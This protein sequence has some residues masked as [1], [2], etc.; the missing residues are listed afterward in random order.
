MLQRLLLNLFA[1]WFRLSRWFPLATMQRLRDAIAEGERGHAGELCLAIEARYS[2]GAVLRGL[3]PRERA[4]QVFSLLRVWDTQDNSG[5]LLYLQL[6]ERRVELLAD[7]GIAARVHDDQWRAICDQFA[8]DMH[9]GPADVAALRCL[10][11][12]NA[13]LALH[14]PAIGDNPRELPDEPVVL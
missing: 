4:Q 5:V 6:A 13:L 2:P 12:I 11:K 3:Q 8:R 10:E 7:R 9:A 14:F 1:G